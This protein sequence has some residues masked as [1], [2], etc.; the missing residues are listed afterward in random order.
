MTCTSK[1][2]FSDVSVRRLY[3]VRYQFICSRHLSHTTSDVMSDHKL[4]IFLYVTL[5]LQPRVS[6]PGLFYVELHRSCSVTVLL[7]ILN[8]TCFQFILI[9]LKQVVSKSFLYYVHF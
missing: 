5:F 4:D 7:E 8:I 3:T 9:N 2:Y 1:E 6:N